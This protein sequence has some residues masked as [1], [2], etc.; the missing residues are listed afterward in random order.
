[1]PRGRHR[2]SS[3]L[4]R[5]SVLTAALAPALV[6][7]LL[8]AIGS[9]TAVLRTAVLCAAVS[10]GAVLALLR[11]S[12]RGYGRDL[13][14]LRRER[15]RMTEKAA[16]E[17]AAHEAAQAR[18]AARERELATAR[19]RLA[20]LRE[21]AQELEERARQAADRAAKLEARAAKIE[22]RAAEWESRAAELEIRANDLAARTRELAP[23]RARLTPGL[24]A[25]GAAAL[26]TLER[27]AA[28]RNAA[29]PTAVRA[30]TA[31][32]VAEPAVA[33]VDAGA[34]KPHTEPAP[35]P[36]PQ[37]GSEPTVAETPAAPV[38]AAVTTPAETNAP[39]PLS[40]AADA[41]ESSEAPAPHGEPPAPRIPGVRHRPIA[42]E[43]LVPAYAA[44]MFGV[45]ADRAAEAETGR[46]AQRDTS[47][48]AADG[49]LPVQ[50]PAAEVAVP[51]RAAGE[52]PVLDLG[53][54]AL[55]P[56]VTALPADDAVA[57]VVRDVADTVRATQ[58]R[59]SRATG[60]SSFDFFGRRTPEAPPAGSADDVAPRRTAEAET[61]EDQA[62][63]SVS[64][65]DEQ[66]PGHDSRAARVLR[67]GT[68]VLAPARP[69][70]THEPGTGRA[71]PVDLT[72]HDDTEQLPM[73]VD[74]RK[75]A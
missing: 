29:E 25:A 51:E 66:A 53:I 38:V 5:I 43:G 62:A 41:T 55:E 33:R 9:G 40:G 70:L 61:A 14:Q 59:I 52:A 68:Q 4:L 16:E 22:T 30:E 26:L 7:V 60:G 1:M 24:F 23:R 19:D 48:E 20:G 49:L 32:P 36:A 47:D 10:A 34:D 42:V 74:T 56:A 17:R 65:T 3:A 12:R 21:R 31:E 39:A 27:A 8:A 28:R 58:H 15:D 6:G 67:P 50:R 54:D 11:Q 44:S 71:L 63:A 18:V 72:A 46:T 2:Q 45:R 64:T 75:H 73:V 57:R 13:A 35:E 69:L 37:A